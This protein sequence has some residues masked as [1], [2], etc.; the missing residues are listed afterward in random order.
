MKYM[1]LIYGSEN[2]IQGS[3][4]HRLLRRMGGVCASNW[5]QPANSWRLAHCNQCATA[6]SVRPADGKRIVTE[7][8]SPKTREQLGGYFIVE[9]TD[10][11]D[12]IEIA[13]KIPGGRFG[14]IEIRPMVHVDGVPGE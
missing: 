1:M 8:R 11:D 13:K 10:L 12:A 5:I 6:T 4:P 7:D 9:A 3:G 14:T 2:E